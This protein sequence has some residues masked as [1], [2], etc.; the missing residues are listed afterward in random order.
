MIGK[1]IGNLFALVPKLRLGNALVCKAP[2]LRIIN[3]PTYQPQAPFLPSNQH[4]H[5]EIRSLNN[6]SLLLSVAGDI[7]PVFAAGVWGFHFIAAV[8]AEFGVIIIF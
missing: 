6:I 7:L 2:A 4:S 3:K 8:V 5:T 1:I